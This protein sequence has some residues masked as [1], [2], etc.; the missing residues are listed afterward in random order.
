MTDSALDRLVALAGTERV[1][2]YTRQSSTGKTVRVGAYTRSPGK[3]KNNELADEILSL[4]KS[5]G[6]SGLT[7]PQ[8]KNRLKALENEVA[9]RKRANAWGN[10][11]K[12]PT[13]PVADLKNKT[14]PGNGL[15]APAEK[16]R[17]DEPVR[18][19]VQSLKEKT[20]PNAAAPEAPPEADPQEK[21]DF[22]YL[23]RGWSGNGVDPGKFDNLREAMEDGDP[24]AVEE[25]ANAI[26]MDIPTTASVPFAALNRIIKAHGGGQ[27]PEAAAPDNEK[28]SAVDSLKEKSGPPKPKAAPAPKPA[29]AEKPKPK[30]LDEGDDETPEGIWSEVTGEGGMPQASDGREYVASLSPEQMRRFGELHSEL[31]D[32]RGNPRGS[33]DTRY[34]KE[35]ELDAAIGITPEMKRTPKGENFARIIRNEAS[36]F[37]RDTTGKDREMSKAD[38]AEKNLGPAKE[39]V[40][41]VKSMTVAD[42]LKGVNT[43]GRYKQYSYG[44]QKKLDDVQA[45]IDSGDTAA[46]LKKV[47]ALQYD[48]DVNGGVAST[49]LK[50][51]AKRLKRSTS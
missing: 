26:K 46:A 27:K 36:Q 30:T 43:G 22:D 11:E 24:K 37:V 51:L 16:P 8:E 3:M 12:K 23:A 5:P 49:Y 6:S 29:E 41:K 15:N 35:Q 39:S 48:R 28:K 47:E 42:L 21:K 40:G 38:R 45:S 17:P 50:E 9:A 1:S 7:G 44:T 34:Q 10:D 14:A 32:D 19:A 4:R 13:G 20:S 18:N 31:W 33:Y 2:G 25:A